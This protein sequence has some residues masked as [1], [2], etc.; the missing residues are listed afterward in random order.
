MSNNQLPPHLRGQHEGNATR[1]KHGRQM[2]SAGLTPPT[3]RA[4]QLWVPPSAS[5]AS[6]KISFRGRSSFRGT[7]VNPRT[8]REMHYESTLERDAMYI[9]MA[10]SDVAEI[11]DQ[12][13]AVH[14]FDR[15]GRRRHHWFDLEARLHCGKRYA[16]AIKP[17]HQV[18][19]SGILDILQLI[20]EQRPRGCADVVALRTER[21]IT[22]ARA[23][24][25]RLIVR[26]NGC[27]VEA[28]VAQ[29]WSFAQSLQRPVS[30]S[31]ILATTIPAAPGFM[32]LVCL[33]GD[34]LLVPIGNGHISYE[35]R[36]RLRGT[37]GMEGNTN[38]E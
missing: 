27:R 22:R 38:G 37:E 13:P 35:T 9:L 1:R 36:V 23:S 31:D 19:E 10:R 15:A 26:A 33:I 14:Y 25:A 4:G 17:E 24:N 21:Q 11:R 18:A 2:M 28:D 30:I 6:R 12:P 16:L 7:I 3:A 5:L 8:N 20:R 34:G 32:A 29:I